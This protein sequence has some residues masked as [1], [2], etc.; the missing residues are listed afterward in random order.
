MKIILACEGQTEV[1]LL[2][3]LINR[4]YLHFGN[5]LLL[6]K[7]IKLRQLK[8]IESIINTLPIDE[9]IDIYRIGD[10]LKE[11]LSKKGFELREKHI[12]EIK[13]CTKTEIEILVIINEN[14]LDEYEKNKNTIKPKQFIKQHIKNFDPKEYFDKHDMYPAICEYKRIKQHKKDEWCLKDLI[15]KFSK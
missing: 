1:Y 3:N 11:K 5:D 13:I 7:P 4:G 9:Y 8:E 2:E 10:T 6:D 14:L 15:D 12:K